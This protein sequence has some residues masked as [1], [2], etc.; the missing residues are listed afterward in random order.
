MFG[1]Y[2]LDHQCTHRGVPVCWGMS[3]I[4][5]PNHRWALM[6]R[7]S[8]GTY[9]FGRRSSSCPSFGLP[10][11]S[12]ATLAVLMVNCRSDD[13]VQP[14]RV[15]GVSR[16]RG[17]SQRHCINGRRRASPHVP[18]PTQGTQPTNGNTTR[19]VTLGAVCVG[20]GVGC[21]TGNSMVGVAA[22][23]RPCGF[24]NK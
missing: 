18:N 23:L 21:H 4:V 7:R 9:V 11:V 16:R 15:G 14:G 24:G 22:A 1:A 17:C 8:C 13:A 12:D 19:H 2:R 20:E 10:R 5:S 3:A 6:R